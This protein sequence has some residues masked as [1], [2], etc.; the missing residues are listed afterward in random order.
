MNQSRA[1]RA[2]ALAMAGPLGPDIYYSL[3]GLTG[4]IFFVGL[5]MVSL[6]S[7][8]VINFIQ[9]YGLRR[10]KLAD[11][12]F[13]GFS[14]AHAWGSN[15]LLS[16][17]VSFQFPHHADHHL[18]ARRPYQLRRHLEESPQMPIGYFGLFFMPLIPPLWFKVVNPHV[19]KYYREAEI[20]KRND[21][22]LKRK[23]KEVY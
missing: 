13:E 2:V 5:C 19:L 12:R 7:Y 21:G 18:N 3:F 14:P 9:H 15:F 23:I 22:H 10:H 20:Q 8:F 17:M 4:I 1:G 6:L 11:G 16:N